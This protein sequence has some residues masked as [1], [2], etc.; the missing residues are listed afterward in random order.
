MDPNIKN[1]D[2]FF[3]RIFQEMLNVFK[4][5][6]DYDVVGHIDLIRR[7]FPKAH[8]HKLRESREVLRELLN[9]IID[10]NKG[11]EINTGGLFYRSASLNPSLDIL[12][13]YKEM[14]GEIITI[15]SDSHR[16]KRVM[17]NYT[18]GM[19]SLKSAGF[20]YITTY[21]QRKAEFHKIK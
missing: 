1:I 11:I 17:T 12:K 18:K 16:A 7:Y 19:E 4:S 14:G 6:S 9:H 20:K 2:N 21:N 8:K 5:Y 10:D 13:L 15:G 3:A